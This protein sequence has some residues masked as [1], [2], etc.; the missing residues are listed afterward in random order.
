MGQLEE[1]VSML[2]KKKVTLH[3][4]DGT[5]TSGVRIFTNSMGQCGFLPPGNKSRGYRFQPE[6]VWITDDATGK[7]VFNGAGIVVAQDD[8]PE[9]SPT[10]K[11]ET[12]DDAP[13][14]EK[15]LETWWALVS[16][17]KKGKKQKGLTWAEKYKNL[18][19]SSDTAQ[20][21]QFF[22]SVGYLEE[23]KQIAKK[24]LQSFGADIR[25]K[26]ARDADTPAWVF[27]LLLEDSSP[28]VRYAASREKNYRV[29]TNRSAG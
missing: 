12:S 22:D 17:G 25:K 29:K 5:L 24:F 23:H 18:W 11:D 15:E 1:T 19:R 16:E 26:L 27:D 28:S 7:M 3:F 21:I 2:G 9:P 14:S 8:T 4:K 10:A 20:L 6:N 13:M